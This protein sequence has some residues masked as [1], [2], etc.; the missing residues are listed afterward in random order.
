MNSD[1]IDVALRE[2]TD[3]RYLLETLITAS[4]SFDYFRAKATLEE[5]RIKVKV[6]ARIQAEMAAQHGA[7]PEQIIPFPLAA[8]PTH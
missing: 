6:L 8:R 2:I 4:E 3:A 1:P 7:L 5:L